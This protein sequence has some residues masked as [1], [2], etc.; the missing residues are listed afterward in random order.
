MFALNSILPDKYWITCVDELANDVCDITF[1]EL[2]VIKKYIYVD[3]VKT[4][5]IVM[6]DDDFIC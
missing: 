2:L 4:M 1:R 6:I 5:N 3:G